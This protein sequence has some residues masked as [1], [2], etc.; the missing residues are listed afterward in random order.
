MIGLVFG[1]RLLWGVFWAVVWA[2]VGPIVGIA[3][4]RAFDEPVWPSVLAGAGLGGGLGFIY[5][6]VWP[7]EEKDTAKQPG[8]AKSR[9]G[10]E[11]CAW[12]RGTGIEKKGGKACRSCYG[13]GSVLAVQPA[14]RCHR[15][16]GKGRLSLGRRCSVCEG[17]GWS[18][19]VLLDRA[20]GLR[21]AD[22]KRGRGAGA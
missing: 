13:P 8:R 14:R 4:G 10:P 12:C 2:M 16:K 7:G 17:A 18:N 11:S 20:I 19:Y 3:F 15:C 21:A 5:G 9:F 1:R 6:L 22:R